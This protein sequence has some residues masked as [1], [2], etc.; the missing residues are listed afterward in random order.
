MWETEKT[1]Y[2]N[3]KQMDR[4]KYRKF[5]L[6]VEKKPLKTTTWLLSFFFPIGITK[7]YTLRKYKTGTVKWEFIFSFCFFAFFYMESGSGEHLIL[8]L[9]KLPWG[10]KYSFLWFFLP[11]LVEVY[12]L[13]K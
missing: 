13:Q 4:S 7:D 3:W 2:L 10:N 12:K 6:L 5:I 8:I 11:E 1:E 9:G